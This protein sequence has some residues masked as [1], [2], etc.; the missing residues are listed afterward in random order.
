MTD[1]T[2]DA[3]TESIEET[4]PM[5]LDAE[6]LRIGALLD[7][8]EA[9]RLG[10][11][12]HEAFE[13]AFEAIQADVEANRAGGAW[14]ALRGLLEP[15]QLSELAAIDLDILAL[16]L[17][18]EARPTLAARIHALQPH[19]A[20]PRPSLS[21]TQEVMMLDSDA[22]LTLLN[23]RLTPTAP[24]VAG[25]LLTVER[26]GDYRTLRPTARATRVVFDRPVELGTPPGADLVAPR[27]LWSDLVLPGETRAELEELCAWTL[28]RDTVF[29]SWKGRVIGGPLALFA[30]PSGVGKS[31]AAE[32]LAAEIGRAAGHPYALYRVDLGRIMSKYVGETERNLNALLDALHGTRAVLQIDE[33]DGLLGKRGD[34]NDARD[35]YANLE[36]SHLLS[37]F[38]RHDGPVILTT[39]LRRNIDNA[40]ARRFQFVIDFPAPDAV[41]RAELW[42][43]LIPP[44]APCEDIG[45]E[46]LGEALP[47][48]GGAIHNV[49][50]RAAV[51]AATE[52]R[53]ISYRHIARAAWRELG[54]DARKVRPAELGFLADHLEDA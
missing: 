19:L 34:V 21:L 23:E 12:V 5:T 36:V 4:G 20:V 15:A 6:W 47:F 35:R 52:T 3:G 37:R 38:E 48:H 53:P 30:G 13:S 2:T 46:A 51:L 14:R 10:A 43:R 40:F 33:A 39:N 54:K 28:A 16:T 29:G 31:F 42:Q 45:F 9:V 22:E 24:L 44:A 27:G 11:A 1:A 8:I 25:G 7:L 17:A 50:I 32:V 49:A 41:L 18:G 26:E